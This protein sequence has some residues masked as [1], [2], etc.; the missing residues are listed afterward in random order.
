[1]VKRGGFAALAALLLLTLPGCFDS[2]PQIVNVDPDRGS[3]G[4]PA[5][6][7]ISVIFD[8]GVDRA[9][10][11]SRFSV[12]PPLKCDLHSAFEERAGSPC[13]VSWLSGQSGF[14]F[15]HPGALFAANTKYVF[16]LE[17]GVQSSSG[18]TN[19]LNHDWDITSASA[20]AV[21]SVSPGNNAVAVPIDL[22]LVVA[23]NR[24]MT[25]GP[26][27]AAITLTPP[28]PGTRVLPNSVDRGRFLLVP[29]RLLRPNS[30][31]TLTIGSGALGADGQPLPAAQQVEF[32]TGT[33]STN[34]HAAVITA[35]AGLPG[36]AVEMVPLRGP[37]R[38]DPAAMQRILTAPTCPATPG[39]CGVV[40]AGQ[41][42]TAYQAATL[43]PDGT[44]LATVE[45]D[46]TTASHPTRVAV[47]DV[48]NQQLLKV[49][50]GAANP[51]WSGDGLLGFSTPTG[52]GIY[53]PSG[54]RIQT[55][56]TPVTGPPQWVLDHELAVT[57][58]DGQP[59]SLVNLDAGAVDPVPQ[60][61]GATRFVAGP[62]GT[63]V[64]SRAGS[65]GL[66][67]VNLAGGPAVQSL[68]G[69]AVAIGFVAGN[70]Q[71]LAVSG[72]HLVRIGLGD[73][74]VQTISAGPARS[75]FASVRVLP[76]GKQLGWVTHHDG[77]DQVNV[78]NADGSG[79]TT[80][81]GFTPGTVVVGLS[82]SGVSA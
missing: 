74:S 61:G 3:I 60:T 54:D 36:S 9:S 57:G 26:T 50:P 38:G 71:V 7:P 16:H 13:Y 75:E 10:V 37:A 46:L 47:Y 35:T 51:V 77:A 34:Q 43:S 76:G 62:G 69:P 6:A 33:L 81:T 5:N 73:G 15:Y 72:S 1:V 58:A 55:L 14:T 40:P 70:N 78:C 31:Y 63:I 27:E 48:V 17:S 68:P 2:P 21:A 66:Y 65:S 11:A 49:I 32:T 53:H 20:P 28:V 29:G 79:V 18:V 45:A 12:T 25:P 23:F 59:L 4:V 22:P 80:V 56:A 67:A 39:G 41:A 30:A 52:L 44:A 42:V 24:P 82:F 19:S 64:F 8:K